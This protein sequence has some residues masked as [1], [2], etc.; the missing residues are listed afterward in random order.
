MVHALLRNL[1]VRKAVRN[2]PPAANSGKPMDVRDEGMKSLLVAARRQS[3]LAHYLEEEAIA[4]IHRP[5][6]FL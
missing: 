4:R 2:V 3:R 1:R 6:L 5:R